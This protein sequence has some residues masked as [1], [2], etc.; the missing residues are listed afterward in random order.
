MPEH[1]TI[2]EYPRLLIKPYERCEDMRKIGE[3]WFNKYSHS[4]PWC[5]Q[6]ADC[7]VSCTT[8]DGARDW[9]EK[10]SH[11]GEEEEQC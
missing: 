4:H 7:V 10:Y 11:A 1:D 8:E 3:V 6:C 2:A 5:V 9:A